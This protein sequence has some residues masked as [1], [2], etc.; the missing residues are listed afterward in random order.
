MFK[1]CPGRDISFLRF[2]LY[3]ILKLYVS[4]F[5]NP[6]VG[7]NNVWQANAWIGIVANWY[8]KLASFIYPE[9]SVKSCLVEIYY[10][11]CCFTGVFERML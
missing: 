4:N 9:Q 10:P 6:A 2:N 5:Q 3:I 11:C 8:L 1:V 7:N